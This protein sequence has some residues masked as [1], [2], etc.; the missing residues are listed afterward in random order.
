MVKDL[1]KSQTS[2]RLRLIRPHGESTRLSAHLRHA[3]SK[4][5]QCRYQRATGT[6]VYVNLLT[7]VPVQLQ[8]CTVAVQATLTTD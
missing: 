8:T 1:E 6:F 5:A 4:S 3:T 7:F 2:A